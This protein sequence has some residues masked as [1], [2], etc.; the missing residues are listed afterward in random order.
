MV[1]QFFIRKPHDVFSKPHP[2]VAIRFDITGP[3]EFQFGTFSGPHLKE[4]DATTNQIDLSPADF[5]QPVD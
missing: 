5:D 3:L 1:R 4:K 2:V